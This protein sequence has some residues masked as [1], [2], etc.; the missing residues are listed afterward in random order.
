MAVTTLTPNQLYEEISDLARDQGVSEKGRW[1]ELVEEVVESHLA[2]GEIDLD[3]DTEGMKE[4]LSTRWAV[5]KGELADE[6]GE[7]SVA[8]ILEDEDKEDKK[9][10]DDGDMGDEED[11]VV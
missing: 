4:T 11:D 3:D 1:Q 2:M 8:A 5:Y 7:E 9:D 10:K 6:Q